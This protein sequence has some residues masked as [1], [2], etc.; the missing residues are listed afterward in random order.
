MELLGV[1]VAVL[2]L[3][4]KAAQLF[5]EDKKGAQKAT[6]TTQR[7]HGFNE[8]FDL[9]EAAQQLEKSRKAD[10]EQQMTAH[11][12]IQPQVHAHLAPDCEEHDAPGSLGE[13]SMEGKDPCHAEQLP[14]A[15][16]KRP[17]TDEVQTAQA[18]LQMD[19]SGE[20]VARAFIMQEVLTR[21]CDRRRRA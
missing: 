13:G 20:S 12:T 4:G 10:M 3:I 9:Q 15:T 16:Q 2:V 14:R 18:G 21:P 11:Q 7:E 1:I 17:S 8:A 5:G 6:N 19:W